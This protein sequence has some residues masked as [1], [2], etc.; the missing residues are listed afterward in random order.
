MKK[1][2]FALASLCLAL[3]AC[4]N[5]KPAHPNNGNNQNNHAGTAANYN[6]DNT[7]RNVRDR[8]NTLTAG[9]QPENEAD[10]TITQRVR[11]AVVEDDSF[12]TNAKNVKIITL[13]GVVTLRGPVNS[14]REKNAIGQ[15]A[16][17]VN[18][19]RNVDNLL[20]VVAQ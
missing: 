17:A 14:E 1:Q 4:D 7:G 6:A 10:R 19:V 9:E 3:T 20:E 16:K 5:H 12:S 8:D 15:K 11:Q 2:L 13:N 18:G